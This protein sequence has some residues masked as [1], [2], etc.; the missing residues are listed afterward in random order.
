MRQSTSSSGPAPMRWRLVLFWSLAGEPHSDPA[1]DRLAVDLPALMGRAG[2][3]MA[4]AA[5]GACGLA[6]N[7]RPY[8]SR[9]AEDIAVL[10]ARDQPCAGPGSRV[11]RPA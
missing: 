4:V 3:G 8:P 1:P 5:R 9:A 11:S 10:V 2:R 7:A 6:A